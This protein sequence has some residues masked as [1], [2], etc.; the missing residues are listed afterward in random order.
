MTDT[1]SG[2]P[3]ISSRAEQVFPR[4]TPAQIHRIAAHGHMRAMQAGELLAEPGA[5]PFRSSLW[6]PEN[7]RLCV[8]RAPL[9]LLLRSFVP[10]N[11]RVR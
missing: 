4:L 8:L 9:K 5:A 11:S 3:L 2:L 7:C 10:V 1:T 6:F